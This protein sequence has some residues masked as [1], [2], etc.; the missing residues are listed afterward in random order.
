MNDFD[1]HCGDNAQNPQKA[2]TKSPFVANQ[3]IHDLSPLFVQDK[4]GRMQLFIDLGKQMFSF[5]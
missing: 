5:L 4:N 2:S 3:E 1:E